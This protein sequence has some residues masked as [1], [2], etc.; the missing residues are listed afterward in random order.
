MIFT[1]ERLSTEIKMGRMFLI[2]AY[3]LGGCL[4]RYLSERDLLAAIN[5]YQIPSERDS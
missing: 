5:S 3:I 4:S 1:E 2:I